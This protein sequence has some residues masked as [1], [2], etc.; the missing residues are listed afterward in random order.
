[1]VRKLDEMFVVDLEVTCRN[2]LQREVGT[3]EAL[4][5][6]GLPL[7]GSVTVPA[8]LAHR[9]AGQYLIRSYTWYRIRGTR[10]ERRR[11]AVADRA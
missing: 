10:H 3:D 1:M 2:A 6:L 9:A 8:V 11:S 5:R 4:R 7:G